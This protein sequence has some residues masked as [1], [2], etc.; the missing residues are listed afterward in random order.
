MDDIAPL[1]ALVL[2]AVF[3]GKQGATKTADIKPAAAKAQP[4]ISIPAK[5]PR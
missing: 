4:A 5:R 2:V 3:L 1:I